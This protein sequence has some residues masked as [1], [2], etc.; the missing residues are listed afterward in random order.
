KP[1]CLGVALGDFALQTG[2]GNSERGWPLECTAA[3]GGSRTPVTLRKHSAVSRGQQQDA[4]CAVQ[5]R[6]FLN[7]TSSCLSEA[8]VSEALSGQGKATQKAW[9]S[10]RSSPQQQ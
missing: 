1:P 9:I 8:A 3:E 6:S 10:Y 5:T 4:E 7:A 2:A